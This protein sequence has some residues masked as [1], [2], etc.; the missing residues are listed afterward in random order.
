ML[1]WMLSEEG[2]TGTDILRAFFAAAPP[3][4]LPSWERSICCRICVAR[5]IT[6]AG[7]PAICATWIP[8]LWFEPPGWSLRVKITWSP[9][10][11]TDT[12]KL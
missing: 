2:S 5:S 3:A 8:K 6:G 4:T 11:R 9:T 12:L 1:N 7:M 10:S